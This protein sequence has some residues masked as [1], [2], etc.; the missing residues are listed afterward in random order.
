MRKKTIFAFANR[1]VPDSYVSFAWA[2]QHYGYFD[3]M[4]KSIV[5]VSLKAY[6]PLLLQNIEYKYVKTKPTLFFGWNEIQLENY[7]V[8]IATPE[9]ALIDIINFHKS[10]S[11][12]DLVIEK[13]TNYKNDLNIKQLIEYLIKFPITTIKIFGFIFDLLKIDSSA[14][15]VMIKNKSST[16]RMFESSTMFNSKWRLYY[17]EHFSKF[18]IL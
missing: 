18:S 9:K 15:H 16:H 6:K 7:T 17:D 12:I 4:A 13:L 3:Q 10:I 2:L 8:R 5:S 1:L 11:S 14:L